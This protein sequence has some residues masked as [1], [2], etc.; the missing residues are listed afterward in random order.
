MRLRSTAAGAMLAAV[1]LSTGSGAAMASIT[2]AQLFQ[3]AQLTWPALFPGT[4]QSFPVSYQGK[5]FDVRAYANGNY[6]GVADGRAYGLGSF[7]GGALQDFGDMQSFA[8]QVCAAVGC[9]ANDPQGGS[10]NECTLPASQQLATGTRIL[11]TH[12][13][14]GGAPGTVV[15]TVSD[16]VVNGP[17]TFN[18]Q[19]ATL[20]TASVQSVMNGTVMMSQV[21]RYYDQVADGEL[22][23]T[24][25]IEIDTTMGGRT[26]SIR[27]TNQPARLN[28]EFTLA[29]GGSLTRTEAGTTVGLSPVSPPVTGSATKTYVFEARETITVQGRRHDTCRYRET[30]LGDRREFYR[31]FIVGK[32]IP[33][34]TEDRLNGAA[35]GGSELTSGSINGVPL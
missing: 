2:N 35:V 17:A 33:A 12:R 30:V 26:S 20:S 27:V 21:N 34:K 1:L 8:A 11:T 28:D 6:L 3:W 7:T 22:K 19:A 29:L 13:G 5:T 23:R 16:H 10:L 31:W 32:G 18:G 4:P 9:S 15:E 25:G 24:L 14:V